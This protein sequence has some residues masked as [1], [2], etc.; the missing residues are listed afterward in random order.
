MIPWRWAA[1]IALLGA[2]LYLLD[3]GSLAEAA[4]T[5][6]A[7]AFAVAV[8]LAASPMLPLLVRWYLLTGRAQGWLSTTGRFLYANLLNTISPG[9]IGGDV[10]RFFAFRGTAQSGAALFAVLIRERLLG[11]ASMLFGLA[12]G[13]AV[14]E[15][16]ITPTD[17]MLV[18][19][20]GVSAALGLGM[21][22]A[23]PRFLKHLPLPA[24]WRE[25]LQEAFSLDD[26]RAVVVLMAWSLVALG[27]WVVA[28]QFVAS[29]MG[30]GI[31]WPIVLVVVTAVELVRIVPVTIQ[32]L[33]LREGA[34]AGLL[35]AFGYAPESGF[36]LGA[37]VYLA[38]SL[39]LVFTGALGAA[40]LGR[41]GRT[42]SRS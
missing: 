32:G 6:S 13:A 9:N 41:E 27:L 25:P 15:A 31:S 20:L 12:T 35:G 26:S 4:K 3:W 38:L 19:L 22:I 36:V 29:R 8:L 14:I 24:S 28:V 5:V 33:G 42:A 21:L 40:I 2:G 7:W 16:S 11:L 10:Y 23:L 37:V 34:F 17:P 18:R 39:A 30:L 1:S